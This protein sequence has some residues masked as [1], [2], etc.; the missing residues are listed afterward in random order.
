MYI[1]IQQN[2]PQDLGKGLLM[3]MNKLSI[4]VIAHKAG[5]SILANL[6]ARLLASRDESISVGLSRANY[7]R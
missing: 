6:K 5:F 2:N 4:I 3:K 1:Y 7:G